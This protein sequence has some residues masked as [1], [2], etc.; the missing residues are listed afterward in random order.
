MPTTIQP[1]YYVTVRDGARVGFL[2]GPYRSKRAAERKVGVATD[3]AVAA[4]PW[5]W[6]AAFGVSR[7]REAITPR[8]GGVS[9]G[10]L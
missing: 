2:A 4:D 10:V 6:F 3:R 8:R 7:V 1:G 9:F 5:S